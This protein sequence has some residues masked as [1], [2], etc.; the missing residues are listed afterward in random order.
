[1]SKVRSNTVDGAA[2]AFADILMVQSFGSNAL[3]SDF[4]GG[5]RK[6]GLWGSISRLASKKKKLSPVWSLD[7]SVPVEE[8]TNP[9]L[10]EAADDIIF[11][12]SHARLRL[13]KP[14][15]TGASVD[16]IPS[17]EEALSCDDLESAE[18]STL[19]AEHLESAERSWLGTSIAEIKAAMLEVCGDMTKEKLIEL[20]EFTVEKCVNYAYVLANRQTGTEEVISLESFKEY[21]Y[22][23]VELRKLIVRYYPNNND[24]LDE[25]K[26]WNF[27][28]EDPMKVVMWF[29]AQLSSGEVPSELRKHL[30]KIPVS[31]VPCLLSSASKSLG[32]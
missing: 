32:Q 3:V 24:V 25:L 5:E 12:S 30:Q 27:W 29:V 16:T 22:S 7:V 23:V 1:L 26:Y 9:V 31:K 18:G 4:T 11:F 19:G 17:N 21:F 14:L 8:G 6:K 20:L 10:C 13:P 28:F 2:L 15:L